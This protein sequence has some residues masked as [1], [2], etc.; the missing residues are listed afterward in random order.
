M[1]CNAAHT[2]QGAL[3]EPVC[4]DPVRSDKPGQTCLVWAKVTIRSRPKISTRQLRAS[5][6]KQVG[7]VV[8]L[9]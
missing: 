4:G 2:R 9:L 7:K 6:W 3:E 1:A 8:P 5:S